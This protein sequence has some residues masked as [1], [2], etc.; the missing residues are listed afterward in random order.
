MKKETHFTSIVKKK[1]AIV[2]FSNAQS[3]SIL[4]AAF[5]KM[6]IKMGMQIFMK[7]LY[8]SLEDIW[9]YRSQLSLEMKT[10]I[11]PPNGVIFNK[12]PFEMR[13]INNRDILRNLL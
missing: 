1:K 2:P 13:G 5:L 4:I 6:A 9:N 10:L 7:K 8:K 11:C 3:K 12:S